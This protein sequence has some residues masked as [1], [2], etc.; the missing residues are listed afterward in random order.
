MEEGDRGGGGGGMG[1]GKEVSVVSKCISMY[2]VE[3]KD[4]MC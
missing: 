3:L 2:I 1:E 4:L